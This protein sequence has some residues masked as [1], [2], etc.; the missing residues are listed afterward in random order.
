VAQTNRHHDIMTSGAYG[1]I[2]PA[3]TAAT[4]ASDGARTS[5]DG[6]FSVENNTL[7]GGIPKPPATQL[8]RL[9][10]YLHQ[11]IS[12]S[13][14]DL[15]LL[16][17]YAITGLLDSSSISIWSSFVSMQT[18]NTVYLG[19]GLADP[20]GGTRWIKALTS[21][22]SFCAGSFVF[23]RHHRFWSPRKR[24][25]MVSSH[26]VQTLL[27]LAAAL[28]VMFDPISEPTGNEIGWQTLVPI[29]LVAFQAGG[30]AVTSRALKFNALTS[31]VLTS[32]Y[33]DL[34][35]DPNLLAPLTE[36]V[37]RNQRVAAPIALLV[38]VLGGAVW[39]KSSVGMKGALLTAAGLKSLLVLAWL[40][41]K[42]VVKRGVRSTV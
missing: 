1:T 39:A 34:W 10:S 18:G 29:A 32:I 14:G 23:A 7:L 42:P 41:W 20:H 16:A 22:S 30:Q 37:E 40:L 5:Q 12:T 3:E 6:A 24:W 17:C 38:G 9:Q 19:L 28:I 15:I 25:V 36:N 21:V 27:I 2:N 31:V 33:C 35:S 13:H 11:D 26:L 4:T 8:S